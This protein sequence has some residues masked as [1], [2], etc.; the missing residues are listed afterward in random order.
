MMQNIF[1]ICLLFLTSSTYGLEGKAEER[2]EKLI[3]TFQI[4]RFPNDVCVGSNTR[5]GT[6]YTSAECSDKSGTSSGSCADGFG[7]C[8]TFLITACG[9]SS[10]ENITYWTQPTA[11]ASYGTC[12][13]TVCPVADDICSLRLDFTTFAITGPNSNTYVQVRRKVGQPYIDDADLWIKQGSSFATNCLTDVFHAQGASPSASPPGVCGTLTGEHMY[14]EADEDRCNLLQFNFGDSASSALTNENTRG[15]TATVTQ[16]WDITVTQIECTSLTLPPAG[17]TK[18]FWG[19]GG[20]YTLKSYNYMSLTAVGTTHLAGQHERFCMRRERGNCIACFQAAAAEVRISG[21]DTAGVA[22]VPG[23][24]CGYA[25]TLSAFGEE[26]AD[27]WGNGAMADAEN[28]L[29]YGYDC[30]VIPG[31]F[32]PV[33][34]D[35]DEGGVLLVTQTA[36]LIAQTLKATPN[37]GMPAPAPP[38]ICGNNGG[39]GIGPNQLGS[40]AGTANSGA[41]Y[42]IATAETIA[43]SIVAE[44]VSIC[45]RRAPFALEFL[46][47][48]LEGQGGDELV[49]ININI[50]N[51]E[52]AVNTVKNTG[53]SITTSQIACS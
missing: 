3:S 20:S 1:Y 40:G 27:Q 34:D 24:C 32:V 48:D 11:G 26:N 29:V 25:N 16:T 50:E 51:S 19:A 8:C 36:S 35:N 17:C 53:F 23:G 38:Q 13:L 45:T 30:I 37:E 52:L 9:S 15:V 22:T 42:I 44:N 2:N 47:D 21:G 10:S 18:Y 4:V 28:D 33:S 6:C 12:G 49:D 14:V 5:N 7:V 46:T 31:A 43:N 39:L 41:A